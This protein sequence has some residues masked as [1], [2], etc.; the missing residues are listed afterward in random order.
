MDLELTPLNLFGIQ[1]HQHGDFR[2]GAEAGVELDFAGLEQAV[3]AGLD[4]GHGAEAE[5]GWEDAAEAGRD[6]ALRHG[7]AG[8]DAQRHE[9]DHAAG[10]VEGGVDAALEADGLGLALDDAGQ[11]DAGVADELDD[12]GVGAD[13]TDAPD[14]A[15]AKDDGRADRDAVIPALADRQLLPPAG[16][17]TAHDA[18]VFRA[19]VGVGGQLQEFLKPGDLGLERGILL[20]GVFVGGGEASEIAPRLDEL[21]VGVEA[22]RPVFLEVAGVGGGDGD[23]GLQ[24]D[25]AGAGERLHHDRHDQPRDDDDNERQE[26]AGLIEAFRGHGAKRE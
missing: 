16:E 11:P 24:L 9:L 12:G 7:G 3:G 5:A 1:R 21:A 8:E 13:F 6:E 17:V 22:E 19:V 18:G 20:D 10:G 14:D 4:L 23:G 15:A 25:E 26:G 2:E